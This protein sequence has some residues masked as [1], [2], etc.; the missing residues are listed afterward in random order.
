MAVDFNGS[1]DDA[2]IGIEAASPQSIAQNH[3]AI[4]A[5]LVFFRKNIAAEYGRNAEQREHIG[6]D[7]QAI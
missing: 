1:A 3:F 4:A 6:G 2:A 5:G 7:T